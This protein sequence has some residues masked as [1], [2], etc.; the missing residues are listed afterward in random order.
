MKDKKLTKEQ[1]FA[2]Q[3]CFSL[4]LPLVIV[5]LMGDVTLH[6]YHSTVIVLPVFD[7]KVIQCSQMNYVQCSQMKYVINRVFNMDILSLL[8]AA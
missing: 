6:A 5:E 4:C 2:Y 1:N 8:Y 7:Y 3:Q